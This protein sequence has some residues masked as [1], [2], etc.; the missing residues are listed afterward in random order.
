MKFARTRRR[1]SR[2]ISRSSIRC[3]KCCLG[4]LDLGDKLVIGHIDRGFELVVIV[5]AQL[6]WSAIAAVE[7]SRGGGDPR[8]FALPFLRYRDQGT[9]RR[10]SVRAGELGAHP[11]KA[12]RIDDVLTLLT[13]E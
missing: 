3:S 10:G 7:N 5:R 2:S 9:E 1:L 11:R 12:A 4:S 6:R 13:A 8:G